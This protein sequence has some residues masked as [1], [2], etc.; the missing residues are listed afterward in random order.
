[1][2]HRNDRVLDSFSPKF[3]TN[4]NALLWGKCCRTRKK[5]GKRQREESEENFKFFSRSF[6]HNPNTQNSG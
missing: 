3:L 1:V 6:P 4:T 5:W 2:E